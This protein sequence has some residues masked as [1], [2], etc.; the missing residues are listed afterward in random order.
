MKIYCPKCHTCYEIEVGLIPQDG[1]KL[2][3]HRCGEVWLCSHKDM[4]V[5]D[6]PLNEEAP[7]TVIAN[8]DGSLTTTP[9]PEEKNT[10]TTAEEQTNPDEM[11][12]IF[13]RLKEENDKIVT[14]Q[15]NLPA[16]KKFFPKI[17]RLLG[18]DN[19]LTIFIEI[20]T[21]L[22]IIGLSFFGNRYQI[23]RHFPQ[24][25]HIFTNVGIPARIIGEGLEF[26]NIVRQQTNQKNKIINTIQGF[27]YN[28]T[29]KELEIPTILIHIM[30]EDGGELEQTTKKL[31]IHT[32]AAKDKIPFNLQ[33]E[34]P[35]TAKYIML[36][37]TE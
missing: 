4:S 33:V 26:Q 31:D 16:L 5:Q 12:L 2:R 20:L 22:L 6:S 30:D 7:Q 28:S 34:V 13:S 15:E 35:A 9:A 10:D 1:K 21:I 23:V 36:T 24:I 27:V 11:N 25:E 17:K 29:D 18:W 32:L 14:E 37:F 8:E 19:Y 3:C